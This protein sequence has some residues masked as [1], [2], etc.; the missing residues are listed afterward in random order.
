[1]KISICVG[2]RALVFTFV[3]R[4]RAASAKLQVAHEHPSNSYDGV[5][6]FQE[7]SFRHMEV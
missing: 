6:S 1:M 4:K 7:T 2:F 3:S 5:F